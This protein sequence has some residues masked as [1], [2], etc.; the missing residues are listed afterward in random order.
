VDRA[1]EKGCEKRGGLLKKLDIDAIDLAST[2]TPDQILVLEGGAVVTVGAIRGGS[3]H[4][5]IPDTCHLKLTV[6]SYTDK[7]RRKLLDGIK[8]NY[9]GSLQHRRVHGGDGSNHRETAAGGSHADEYDSELVE[10]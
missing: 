2:A 4:N 8:R 6:R 9:G 1:R 10:T 5:I 7:V 3:K